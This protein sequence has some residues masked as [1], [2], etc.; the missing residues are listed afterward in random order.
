MICFKND[1][2]NFLNQHD[3]IINH[4]TSYVSNQNRDFFVNFM[5]EYAKILKILKN[6]NAEKKI[7]DDI[8]S[9][10]Q[11]K[12]TAFQTLKRSFTEEFAETRR[13]IE[14]ELKEKGTI[15]INLEEYPT[16]KSKISITTQKIEA[17]KKQKYQATSIKKE[18]LQKLSELDTL[19]HNE[20]QK[21]NK[22]LEKINN[23][24]SA[25]T[26][27]ADFK[28]DK[29][30]FLDYMKNIFRGSGIRETTYQKLVDHYLDFGNIYNDFENAKN[31]MG[32]SK[33]IFEKYFF[34]NLNDLLTFQVQ[35]KFTI[36]YRGKALQ[37]HSLGQRASALILFVLNQHE[38]D[39]IIVDQ[40]EDDLDNKTIYE[41]VIKLIRELKP[42]TQFI[43]ATHNANFP[44]LGDAELIHSCRYSDD[45]IVLQSGS[46]DSQSLQKEIVNI[47]EGGEAAFNKRKEIYGIWK[48]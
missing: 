28:G 5:D 38:N 24:H 10:L 19:W 13:K 18:L 23:K 45:E 15:S 37:H 40:P 39:V 46:I 36:K 35:N 48:L 34:E 6:Q 16:L 22:Q 27:E 9:S 2:E 14:T 29:K 41:D 3:K 20:F 7:I 44:V 43:F 26:I 33:E 21:I 8:V 25:L 42:S 32:S 4:H 31:L 12:F 11:A 30:R 1:F 17:L 47:M